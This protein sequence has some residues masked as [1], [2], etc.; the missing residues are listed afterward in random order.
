MDVKYNMKFRIN[1]LALNEGMKWIC[2]EKKRE[3]EMD[4]SKWM[5]I[6]NRKEREKNESSSRKRA[7]TM[8]IILKFKANGYF[9]LFKLKK[10]YTKMMRI[11]QKNNYLLFNYIFQTV[12]RSRTF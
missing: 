5:K 11:I 3:D 9:F 12:L 2:A 1:V 7:M 8:K 10:K 4:N 6:I